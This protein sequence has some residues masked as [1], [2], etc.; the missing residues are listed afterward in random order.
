VLSTNFTSTL[1]STLVNE[2]RFGLR[3]NDTQGRMAYEVHKDELQSTLDKISG[4]PDPGFTR[5]TGTVYP[6]LFY[7][8]VGGVS[9]YNFSGANSLYNTAGSHNGN[10][11]ILYTYG[12]TI[13]WNLGKHALKF[14]GEYRPTSSKAYSNVVAGIFANVPPSAQGGAG[15]FISPI[16]GG[17]ASVIGVPGSALLDTSRNNAANLLYTLSGTIDSVNMLYWM[18]SFQDV[19]DKKWQSIATKPDIYRTVIIN[20]GSFFAKMTGS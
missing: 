4:G 17:G 5:A 2:A 15:A 3:Y 1:S 8:G 18:D 19:Q 11:S 7:A 12:D 13:S 10:K 6:A 14:G 20:E 16:A 9:S